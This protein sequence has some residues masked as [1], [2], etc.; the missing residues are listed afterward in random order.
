MTASQFLGLQ[1]GIRALQPSI[2]LLK[3]L[4]APGLVGNKAAIEL[5][6]EIK[7]SGTRFSYPGKDSL[8]ICY[9]T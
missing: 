7:S 6:P 5:S 2:L 9:V 8:S 3:V 4:H 1:V